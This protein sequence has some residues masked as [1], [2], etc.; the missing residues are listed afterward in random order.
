[1]SIP[2]TKGRRKRTYTPNHEHSKIINNIKPPEQ[3]SIYFNSG[4][5][6]ENSWRCIGCKKGFTLT[7]QHL[8]KLCPFCGSDD[9]IEYH[10]AKLAD[11]VDDIKAERVKDENIDDSTTDTV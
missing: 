7:H 11:Q 10:K 1:M 2:R 9:L 6:P 8:I 4:L 3:E 5:M